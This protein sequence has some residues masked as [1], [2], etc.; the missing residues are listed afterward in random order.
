MRADL[1]KATELVE[2][3][4]TYSEAGE[5]LGLTRNAVAGA[6]R[7][8]GVRVGFGPDRRRKQAAACSA[9]QRARWATLSAAERRRRVG[10]ASAARRAAA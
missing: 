10:S 5:K 8:A 9:G 2:A 7:R 4:L 6:C 3:G 1:V